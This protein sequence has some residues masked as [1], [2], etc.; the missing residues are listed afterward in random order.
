MATIAVSQQ[1]VMLQRQCPRVVVHCLASLGH[2]HCQFPSK[3]RIAEGGTGHDISHGLQGN[4]QVAGW[5]GE[6]KYRGIRIGECIRV[7][8]QAGHEG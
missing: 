6:R 5:Q 2:D 8:A 1:V 4:F 3:G 7:A